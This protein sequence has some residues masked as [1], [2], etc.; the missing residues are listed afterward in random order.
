M[1]FRLTTAINSW[2]EE[3]NIMGDCDI[4]SEAGVTKTIV[5]N[6]ASPEAQYLLTQIKLSKKLHRISTLY[7]MH[8][9]D[10][11]AY[12]GHS[13]F[14]ST[15]DEM[16][17]HIEDMKKAKAVIDAE[18]LGIDVRLIIADMHEGTIDFKQI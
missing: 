7:L 16:N 1:D 13:G 10:C 12:G 18:N 14:A 17:R 3:N 8:H 2:M 5:E 4:I 6:P 11:G 9:T 15:E